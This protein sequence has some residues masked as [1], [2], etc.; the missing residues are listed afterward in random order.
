MT[1]LEIRSFI[2]VYQRRLSS[3]KI[4]MFYMPKSLDKRVDN[5]NKDWNADFPPPRWSSARCV[6]VAFLS[7]GW[8]FD[9][10]CEVYQFQQERSRAYR[11]KWT[12]RLLIERFLGETVIWILARINPDLPHRRQAC[13][14]T[15][16][17]WTYWVGQSR[18]TSLACLPTSEGIRS[19][20]H[21]D[22]TPQMK[23][24]RRAC[25]YKCETKLRD[26]VVS[27]SGLPKLG[28]SESKI[29]CD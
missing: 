18:P 9:V 6:R 21:L 1:L 4:Q 10:P 5:W 16:I 3:L 25:E 24:S 29:S 12:D 7:A 26:R 11:Y 2:L 23:P 15:P 14:W 8:T 13:H 17:E 20:C 19:E 27:C 28:V 22:Q